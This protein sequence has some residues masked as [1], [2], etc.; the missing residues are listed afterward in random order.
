MSRRSQFGLAATRRQ[1]RPIDRLRSAE[2]HFGEDNKYEAIKEIDAA[3]ARWHEDRNPSS[4]FTMAANLY[5]RQNMYA[6]AESALHRGKIIFPE[7]L[8]LNTQLAH[9]YTLQNKPQRAIDILQ[10]FYSGGH[11][12]LRGDIA[13]ANTLGRAYIQAEN[14]QSAIK[15]LKPIHDSHRGD[16][17]TVNIL[18]HAHVVNGDRQSFDRIKEEIQP[19]S[20][21]D[22][23]DAKLHY[24]QN[25]RAKA[26]AL[27]ARHM[28]QDIQVIGF[29]MLALFLACQ[30][31]RTPFLKALKTTAL[32]E[33]EIALLTERADE[34]QRNPAHTLMAD[35]KM[36]STQT[37]FAEGA[38]P[39]SRADRTKAGIP[40]DMPVFVRPGPG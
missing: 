21:R 17:A 3:L 6:M 23:L 26:S 10:P 34:W 14:P 15:L 25:D 20:L 36:A 28:R 33:D 4:L 24:L 35:F 19:P 39:A 11:G 31:D 32:R 18:G 16:A 8:H 38:L 13:A 9:I 7:S 2:K 12:G 37:M 22:Y 1:P 40:K 27:L 29:N 30:G 5:A